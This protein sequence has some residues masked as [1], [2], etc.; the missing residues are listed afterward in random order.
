MRLENLKVE[1]AFVI[2]FGR[3]DKNGVVYSKEAVEKAV[4]SFN[5]EIP[6]IYRGNDV[7]EDATV[8]G[9]TVGETCSVLWDDEHQV[10]E[11]I[12]NGDVYYGGTECVVNEIKNG[13]ITD[14]D[15]VS[16]GFSQR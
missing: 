7:S 14:F 3:P 2:P 11:V 8:I 10:C 12:I 4:S 15:I 6:I 9:N 13:V 16:V 5:G 1:M